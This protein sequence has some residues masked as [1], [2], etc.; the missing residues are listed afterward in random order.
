MIQDEMVRVTNQADPE[1]LY[2]LILS[3][4]I[5]SACC[6]DGCKTIYFKVVWLYRRLGLDKAG[7]PCAANQSPCLCMTYTVAST[8]FA[9]GNRHRSAIRRGEF[10][11]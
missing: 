4:Y 2:A 7:C 10:F 11:H 9:D 5:F 6:I 1:S 3:K 8:G